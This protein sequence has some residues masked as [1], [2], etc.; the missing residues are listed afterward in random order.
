M[1][2]FTP[3][4]TSTK[5]VPRAPLKEKNNLGV[6]I[7]SKRFCRKLFPTTPEKRPKPTIESL[8]KMRRQKRAR[9]SCFE[10]SVYWIY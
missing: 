4:P 9:R 8:D 2:K 3:K 5:A 7:P 6:R 10:I 1:T